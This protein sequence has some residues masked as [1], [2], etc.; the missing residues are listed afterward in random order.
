MQEMS[1]L[2]P[3]DQ[4]LRENS[5]DAL[6]RDRAHRVI[7][8]GMWGHLNVAR[9][10]DGY[11]QYFREARGCRLRDVDG[12]EYIDLMCSYGPIILGHGDEAVEAAAAEQVRRGDVMNGPAECLV[13]LAELLVDTIAH[14]DW[15]LLAKNGTDA[16]TSCVTIAR[17]ESGRRKILVA[18]GSYHGAVPWCTPSVEGVTAEDRAH[19]IQYDYNDVESLV[20][21]A[22]QARGDLAGIIV[23]AFRHDNR[24]DQELP[25]VEFAKTMRRICDEAGAAL[26]LDD[27]RAGFRIHLGG[28]WEPL[29]VR[30]DLSAWSKAIANGYALAAVAGNDRY[31]EAAKKVYVTGSFWASAVPMAAAI[32][33]I[34]KLRSFDAIAH[35]EDVGMRLRAGL[36]K[37]AEAYGF[38]LSQSG[39]VQMPLIRFENDRN[40]ELGNRFVCEV[41]TRGVYMHPW[42]NMFLSLAHTQEDIEQI[43]VATDGAFQALTASRKANR[44]VGA[45]P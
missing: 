32:A 12:Q 35:L 6:L 30:P 5:R 44:T 39:P 19:I 14:A 11:P 7:P 13:E 33:T 41:L 38:A 23:T 21:A 36:Q 4:A 27:V 20:R 1:T 40:L 15:V 37:Q 28:S 2:I 43:L 17:A 34:R 10:P 31:R 8:G 24:R 3:A 45:R 22:E 9:L 26:I 25:R 16:T 18:K 29:G 42:H